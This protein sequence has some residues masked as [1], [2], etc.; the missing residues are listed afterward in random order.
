MLSLTSKHWQNELQTNYLGSL[1]FSLVKSV[2]QIDQY[3]V[4]AIVEF[5]HTAFAERKK[6][7]AP[8]IKKAVKFVKAEFGGH[9][10]G[11]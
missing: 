1:A 2:F 6:N 8:V 3:A 11:I 10:L 7:I 4:Y 9:D 5:E